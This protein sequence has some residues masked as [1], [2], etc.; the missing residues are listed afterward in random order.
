MK[1]RIF[2]DSDFFQSA[3]E[4]VVSE[5][6]IKEII[7]FFVSSP[8]SFI[9]SF[10]KEEYLN[11]AKMPQYDKLILLT[12]KWS[13]SRVDMDF[14]CTI[15]IENNIDKADEVT[16]YFGNNSLCQKARQYGEMCVNLEEGNDFTDLLETGGFPIKK[17]DE[18]NWSTSFKNMPSKICNSMVF[19]DNYI[20]SEIGMMNLECILDSLLPKS[21]SVEFHFTIVALEDPKFNN[22]DQKE[23]IQKELGAWLANYRPNLDLKNLEIL[24]IKK[25]ENHDRYILTNNYSICC[26]SGFDLIKKGKSTRTTSVDIEYPFIRIKKKGEKP[27]YEKYV[28]YIGNVKQCFKR[29]GI[30]SKNRLL[31]LTALY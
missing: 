18:F 28:N 17:D 1:T 25:N 21:L 10:S 6:S 16:L 9:F 8:D 29:R 11:Y 7:K 5:D 3:S 4:R 23:K 20:L 26:Q 14:N 31:S 13:D 2:C 30:E 27:K 22:H 12:K 15:D 19:V 24:F